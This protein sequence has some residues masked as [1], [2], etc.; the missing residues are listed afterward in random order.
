MSSLR[1][2][3]QSKQEHGSEEDEEEE[4][5]E[6]YEEGATDDDD[7]DEDKSAGDD[8]E[9]NDCREKGI[10]NEDSKDNAEAAGAE[11]AVSALEDLLEL[12]FKLSITLS[13][14]DFV[15]GQP[16][17]C[18]LVY[19]SGILGFSA[20]TRAFLPAKRFTPYLSGLIY[21]Q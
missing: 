17:S 1:R 16:S 7:V 13:T 9:Y 20:D 6:E 5:A 11:G 2:K 8:I 14:E 19:Y 12:V 15:D 3:Y 10:T 4:G 18:L 21:I